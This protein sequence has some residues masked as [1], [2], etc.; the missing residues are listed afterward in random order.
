MLSYYTYCHMLDFLCIFLYVYSVH[1]LY[2]VCKV[3]DICILLLLIMRY[4][5]VLLRRATFESRGCMH[6]I[7]VDNDICRG[8]DQKSNFCIVTLTATLLVTVKDT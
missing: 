1:Q 2:A 5:E 3:V 4:V 7:I 8:F 6:I